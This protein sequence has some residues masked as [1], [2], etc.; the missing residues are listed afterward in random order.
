MEKLDAWALLVYLHWHANQVWLA[1]TEAENAKRDVST[2][3]E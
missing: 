2:D 3:P 1:K